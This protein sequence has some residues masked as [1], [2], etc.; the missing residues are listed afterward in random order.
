MTVDQKGRLII[1]PQARQSIPA[2]VYAFPLRTS[3]EI[4]EK[5]SGGRVHQRWGCCYAHNSPLR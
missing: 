5:K 3:D 4:L 2:A 1:S